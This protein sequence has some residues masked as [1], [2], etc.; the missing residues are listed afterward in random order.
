MKKKPK[1]KK[2]Q[3]GIIAAVSDSITGEVTYGFVPKINTEKKPK[4]KP[5]K[6]W[7]YESYEYGFVETTFTIRRRVDCWVKAMW[8]LKTDSR[9]EAMNVGRV[10]RVEVRIL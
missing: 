9:K 10:R 4:Q 1:Q 2:A 8:A 5:L 7:I 3:K 6:G